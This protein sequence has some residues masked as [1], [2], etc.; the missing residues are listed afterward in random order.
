MPCSSI[1]EGGL[2]ASA[3]V[4]DPLTSE[5]RLRADAE[6][7]VLSEYIVALIVSPEDECEILEFI[8]TGNWYSTPEG[9]AHN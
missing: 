5:S 8:T 4:G 6:L 2:H 1:A 3:Q 9:A 7:A